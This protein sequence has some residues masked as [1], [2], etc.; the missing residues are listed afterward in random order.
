MREF[1][2]QQERK[3]KRSEAP[4]V[5]LPVDA[6]EAPGDATNGTAEPAAKKAKLTE[7]DEPEESEPSAPNAASE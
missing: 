1:L 7:E 3:R 4:E 2:A 5:L 6:A